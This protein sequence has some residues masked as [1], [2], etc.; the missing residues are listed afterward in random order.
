MSHEK[1]R[2]DES[3]AIDHAWNFYCRRY[4]SFVH[5]PWVTSFL[6]MD[7]AE[8]KDKLWEIN[9]VLEPVP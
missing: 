9:L 3:N 7:V 2:R 5:R 8:W 6:Y 4:T 1:P